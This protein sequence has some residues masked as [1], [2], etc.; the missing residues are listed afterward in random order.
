MSQATTEPE[1]ILGV[2]DGIGAIRL[3]RPRA[4]NA[5]THEM[6]AGIGAA[7]QEWQHDE[8]VQRIEITGA[9][10]RGMCSGA[11]VRA[12]RQHIV[13]GRPEQ[14]VAFFEL[15]YPINALIAEYPKP[16]WSVMDGITMGGGM[17]LSLHGTR[18]IGT[19]TTSLAMPEVGIGLFPDVGATFELSR[20]PGQT[21]TWM[22]LTG[23]PVDA[24]SALWAGLLTETDEL[25]THPDDSW[26]TVNRGWIDEC[27]AGDDAVEIVGRLGEHADPAARETAAVI[28]GR[29][30][31][32]VA[33][34]L[35]LL[36]RS[37]NAPTV[38]AVTEVDQVLGEHFMHD[39]DF[40]EG[41]RAQLVDKDR[42]PQWRHGS[43]AEVSRDE[44]LGMFEAR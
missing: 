37:A 35:E 13:E 15:E 18:R 25:A 23:N 42:N 38:R 24:S 19:H 44:V 17:G 40:A 1:L 31:L 6:M 2:H 12:L 9:G 29:S 22:A 27:M 30:P 8:R 26:L 21:G 20:M 41:V 36:R 3:N 16:V 39:S 34:T 4:I 5:L 28:S 32:S 11:D 43:L 7:L 14:A 10:E 33:V